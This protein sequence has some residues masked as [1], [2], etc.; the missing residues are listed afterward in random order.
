[1]IR[2]NLLIAL[3]F[4]A[5]GASLVL[6]A[7]EADRRHTA[8]VAANPKRQAPAFADVQARFERWQRGEP[9]MSEDETRVLL[10]AI[11]GVAWLRLL[12]LGWVKNPGKAGFQ[13]RPLG[14]LDV[15]LN[16]GRAPMTIFVM[17]GCA[18]W[19]LWMTYYA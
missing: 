3:L 4:A 11:A 14:P 5:T 1:M 10:V 7:Y 17:L 9:V 12:V 19:A 15:M 18:G 16:P 8:Y 6:V 2:Q 13:R